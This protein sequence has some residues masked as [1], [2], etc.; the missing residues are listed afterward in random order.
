MSVR[1]AAI[2]LDRHRSD[3]QAAAPGLIGVLA[4]GC[5]G[6]WAEQD[7]PRQGIFLARQETFPQQVTNR[8]IH[9]L[10][11]LRPDR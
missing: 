3:L 6:G 1:P 9:S 2:G 8:L 11:R 10:F 5:T 7:R 4:V